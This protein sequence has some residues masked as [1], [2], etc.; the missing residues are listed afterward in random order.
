MPYEKTVWKCYSFV[1][2]SF[3]VFKNISTQDLKGHINKSYFFNSEEHWIMIFTRLVLI[4]YNILVLSSNNY[5]GNT[6]EAN[7]P[8]YGYGTCKDKWLLRL[9][10]IFFYYH[11][12]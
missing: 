3:F 4:L 5:F 8:I 6:L 2:F 7:C 11:W 1:W 10:L 12:D 9:S